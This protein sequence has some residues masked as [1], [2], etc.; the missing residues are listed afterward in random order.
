MA[1]RQPIGVGAVRDSTIADSIAG[2]LALPIPAAMEPFGRLAPLRLPAGALAARETFAFRRTL[3]ARALAIAANWLGVRDGRAPPSRLTIALLG[4]PGQAAPV[5]TVRTPLAP[6]DSSMLAIGDY[7]DL[8][9][10]MNAR[11][12]AKAEQLRTDPCLT[13]QLASQY[14]GCRSP[15]APNFDFQFNVLSGGVVADRVHVNVDYDSQREFDASNNVSV[16]YE[17]KPNEM[18]QRLEVGNVSFAPPPSRFITAGIPSGNYGLQ[19]IGQIGPMRFRAIAAQQKGNVVRDARFTVGD[20]TERTVDRD[21]EDYQVEPRRFF[22]TVDPAQFAGYPN[23]DILDRR[24]MAALS[25]DMAENVR[26]SRV[27]VYRLQIGS[28]PANPNG[29]KFKV[30]GLVS[31]NSGEQPFEL[32]REGVDYYI[33]PSQLWIALSRQ[34]SLDR[35]RIVVAYYVTVGGVETVNVAAGGTPDVRADS[36]HVQVAKLLYDP[37]IKPTDAAFRREIRSVYRIGGDEVRRSTVTARIVAGAGGD[38]EKPTQPAASGGRSFQTYLEMF[39]LSQPTSSASFDAENRVWPRPSDPNISTSAAGG[40]QRTIRDYFVV[41]PSLRPFS[42]QGRVVPGNQANDTIYTTPSEYLYSSQHPASVYRLRVKYQAE[43]SGDPGSLM[44]GAVQIRRNSERL[45]VDGVP[46][47][48]GT[49]YS[50]DYELGRVTFTRPDTL[51]PQPRQ[52]TVQYEENPVFATSATNV[53]GVAATFPSPQGE[54]TFTAISQ[55]QKTQ[56]NRPPLGFEPASSFVAGVSG[57]WLFN[58]PLLTNALARL[59]LSE[60]PGDSRIAIQAELATSRPQPNSIGQAWI[61]TFEGETGVQ[62]STLD[63]AWFY[64]SRPPETRATTAV[65]GP[66]AFSDTRAATLVWQTNISV[67]TPN[68]TDQGVIFTPSRIDPR[69]KYAGQ[70]IEPTES[71]LWLTLFPTTTGFVRDRNNGR[72]VWQT[73]VSAPLQ[74]R[75]RSIRTVL[76]PSGTDLTRTEELQFW[77]LVDTRPFARTHNPTIVVDLGDVSENTL[78]LTPDSLIVTPTSSGVD[79]LYTGRHAERLDTLDTERDSIT[80]SFNAAQND[81][82]IPPDVVRNLAVRNGG[83]V[84]RQRVELCEAQFG[85]RLHIGDQSANCTIRNNR[86]DE[87]DID[88]DFQLNFRSADAGSE[89]FYRYVVNLAD[90]ASYSRRGQ[91]SHSMTV[92]DTLASA[93]Y[94]WVMV[95][96]PLKLPNDTVNTPAL[97]RVKAL[98]LTMVS[99]AG[100]PDDSATTVP[101]ARLRLSGPPWLK[102]S[103]LPL[104][105]AGGDSTAV[106][107]GSAVTASLIGTTEVVYQRPPGVVDEADNKVTQYQAGVTQINESS[108]RL[109]AVNVPQYSRAEAFYRFPEGAKSFLGYRELRVWA[110][111]GT[112]TDGTPSRGWGENGELEFFVRIGRDANNFYLFRTTAQTGSSEAA[113]KDVRVDFGALQSLRA[114]IQ[115]AYLRGGSKIDCTDPVSRALIDRTPRPAL[116]DTSQVY[117]ACDG[118]YIAYTISPGVTP[119]NLAAVQELSVGMV[120]VRSGTGTLPIGIANDTLELWVD[121]I[122]LRNVVDTPGYAGQ[123]GIDISAGGIADLRLVASKRDPYFRQLAEQPTFVGDGGLDLAATVRV[124]RLLPVS[125]GLALPLTITHSGTTASPELLTQ[126]DVTASAIPGLRTPR[127]SATSYAITARRVTPLENPLLSAIFDNVTVNGAWAT[128]GARSEYQT[129]G[130]K[131]WNVGVDYAVAAEPRATAVPAW[132]TRA[133]GVLPPWMRESELGRAIRGASL[134]WN[135]AAIHFTSA[136]VRTTDV[137]R[138]FLKPAAALDDTAQVVNGENHVWRNGAGIELRP[139]GPLTLRWDATSLR[140]LRDYN[141]PTPASVAAQRERGRLFGSDVGLE[142]ERQMSAAVTLAP[143][144]AVWFHPRVDLGSTFS[145]LRDPNATTLAYRAVDTTQGRID[146]MS[147]V[148]PRRFGNT[149]A[150]NASAQFDLQR[151]AR[152]Y[153]QTNRLLRALGNAIAPIELSFNRSL[154]SSFDDEAFSPSLGYQFAFGGAGSMRRIRGRPATSAGLTNTLSGNGALALPWDF[155]LVSRMGR[156][157]SRSWSRRTNDRQDVVD[158]TQVDF[159][160]L[161]LRWSFVPGTKGLGRLAGNLVRSVGTNVGVRNTRVS[162]VAQFGAVPDAR[163]SRIMTYPASAT[164]SW[165]FGDLSTSLGYAW[166]VRDDSLPGSATH[167]TTGERTIDVGRSWGLPASWKTRSPLRTRLAYQEART[168]NV[169]ADSRRRLADNERNV[170]SLSADTDLNETATF[171]LQGSRTMTLDRNYNR[172]LTQNV[173]T[174]ALQLQFFSGSLK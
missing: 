117:A 109:R 74:R 81:S 143:P 45:L 98:R 29:P 62:I 67:P 94:C 112:L 102:R 44:L 49:D 2:A 69:I 144:I 158:G 127:S 72:T 54:L 15:F 38:Q 37:S 1:R 128:S 92:P 131:N 114:R 106:T 116:V 97:R 56:Y 83:A 113:W 91:C 90:T 164:F 174:A 110:R 71:L 25:K 22:F 129:G 147:G 119:P 141:A 156:T 35:D 36:T 40:S 162:S 118:G 140:D 151:A 41:L 34:A 107:A 48:R 154:L 65:I 163:I 77:A 47:A 142:R 126:S 14:Q 27:L 120:R 50:V 105:G 59:P 75:W 133:I 16:Y 6:T 138:T 7:A 61:E 157:N 108:L 93:E 152:V 33:D 42:M 104:A 103:D 31:A 58:A 60:R 80:R 139:A 68:G 39:G 155:A 148:L 46:L 66:G 150:L 8:S 24:Q 30:D 53:F 172:R 132:V 89:S 88:L 137:R 130:A 18:L 123:V 73:G 43:G 125:L 9:L 55:A 165:G 169:L 122:R 170:F 12:E 10:R 57:S 149:Q 134:R 82:G 101:I 145:F 23:I 52:V 4:A 76:S 146:S 168:M 99:G 100:V 124:D 63:P 79:S 167:G 87:E 78:A 32:L 161:T 136:L 135:P 26:P 160:D 19:A 28:Q 51:F 121:D 21:I 3:D 64:S 95:R 17:G 166:T 159:P 13:I 173:L 85:I 84:A 11:L 96:V 171:S 115:N 153:W 20:R 5:D 111:G 70:G 86:L